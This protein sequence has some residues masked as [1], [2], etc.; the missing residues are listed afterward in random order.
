MRCFAAL[1]RVKLVIGSNYSGEVNEVTYLFLASTAVKMISLMVYPKMQKDL[2]F[3][4]IA[5]V[6]Q[7]NVR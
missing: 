6:A 2:T 5:N 3:E 4:E 1:S 7:T